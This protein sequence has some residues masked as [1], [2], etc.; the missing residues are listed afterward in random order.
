MSAWQLRYHENA[1]DGLRRLGRREAQGV[2][3]AM[4]ERI[5]R[6]TSPH[7]SG[8]LLV[9]DDFGAFWRY[10]LD[11]C[12]VLCDIDRGARSITVL[13]VAAA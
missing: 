10:R 6:H 1:V 5:A 11:G 4:T 2:L 13:H 7:E 3:A 12:H 8:E 9:S